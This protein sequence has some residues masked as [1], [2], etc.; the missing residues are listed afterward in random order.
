MDKAYLIL[1]CVSVFAILSFI[2]FWYEFQILGWSFFGI[3]CMFSMGLMVIVFDGFE[4][5]K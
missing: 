2:S 5:K 4:V 1:L 3:C